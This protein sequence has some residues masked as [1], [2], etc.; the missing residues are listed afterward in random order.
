MPHD[1]ARH[2]IC[3]EQGKRVE[4]RDDA[5]VVFIVTDPDLE[6]ITENE[7]ALG[8]H[9]IALDEAYE[10]FDGCR[11]LDVEVKVGDKKDGQ[12]DYSVMRSTRSMTIGVTGTLRSNGPAPVVGLSPM[13]STTSIPSSTVPKTA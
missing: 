11:A 1:I 2:F 3:F 7:Q 10:F 8:L 6:Q 4:H 12:A 5:R 9:G 13:L